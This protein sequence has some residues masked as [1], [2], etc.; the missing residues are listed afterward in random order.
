MDLKV[1]GELVG[2]FPRVGFAQAEI[3][4][5]AV[6][7]AYAQQD[8]SGVTVIYGEFKSIAQQR[9]IQKML[10]PLEPPAEKPILTDFS[11]EPDREQLLDTLLPRYIKA[12]LYRIL[13]ESQAAELAARMNAME[14]ASKNAGELISGLTLRLNRTR[15]AIITKEIAEL[16]GGAEALA[17]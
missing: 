13:L 4:G 7:E 8:L 10:L 2:I 6:L 1:V 16:V 12:Q 11:F 9:V 14:A 5:K 17:S 15:Q 3:L